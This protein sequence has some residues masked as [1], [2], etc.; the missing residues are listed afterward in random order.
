[1]E[2]VKCGSETNEFSRIDNEIEMG[3]CIICEPR[4]EKPAFNHINRVNRYG[5]PEQKEALSKKLELYELQNPKKVVDNVV[6][7]E[8]KKGV[9][10]IDRALNYL[11]KKFSPE[12]KKNEN[13]NYE[14]VKNIFSQYYKQVIYRDTKV[15]ITAKDIE[16]EQ[17]EFMK[18]FI[19]WLIYDESGA[20]DVNKCLYIWG[21][22]G[23]GKSTIVETGYLM[24]S[25]L[26]FRTGWEERFFTF[27]SM[28]ELFLE[29]YA[30]SNLS[31]LG[32]MASGQWC[33]DE[34]REKHLMYKHYGND[35]LIMAD[36]LTARHNLWKSTGSTTIITSNIPP[37]ELKKVF[38][39]DRLFDR[40][41]QQYEPIELI[42]RNKR[43][44]K[45]LEMDL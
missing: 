4:I 24:L 44:P 2:C 30:S 20:Y 34:L 27:V 37:G 40:I 29:M 21:N 35:F 17:L 6:A 10:E 41:Q 18:N 26:K 14:N 31:K 36:L 7:G 8:G 11:E 12:R 45:Q 5:S 28:D 23:V 15:K 19:K 42:G 13:I 43:K 1:M 16:P 38:D 32:K 39:D 33:I 22:L 3:V 25:Y 9:S